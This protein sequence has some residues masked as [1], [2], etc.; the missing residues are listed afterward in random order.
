MDK[1]WLALIMFFKKKKKKGIL[2][3]YCLLVSLE[4]RKAVL[5]H[6]ICGI[7]N[8]KCFISVLGWYQLEV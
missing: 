2:V 7:A 1:S 3:F 8:M 6:E 5:F 4:V